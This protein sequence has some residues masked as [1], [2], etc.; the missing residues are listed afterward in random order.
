[1]SGEHSL[2]WLPFVTH[3][4]VLDLSAVSAGPFGQRLR[5]QTLLAE[6]PAIFIEIPA[7]QIDSQS[8]AALR[9]IEGTARPKFK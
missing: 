4:W 9:Q 7:D 1:M 3:P 5:L 2:Q 8:E 6:L